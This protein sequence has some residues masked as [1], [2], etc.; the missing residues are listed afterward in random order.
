MKPRLQLS[1]KTDGTRVVAD[2][3][4]RD[5]GNAGLVGANGELNANT[6]QELAHIT[7][8]LGQ[9]VAKN[10]IGLEAT[11]SAV[12]RVETARRNNELLL[13]AFESK[14]EL[15]ALGQHMAGEIQRVVTRDGFMRRLLFQETAEGP[16]VQARMDVKGVVAAK[17]TGPVRSEPV[18]VRETMFWVD[19]FEIIA[20][21]FVAQ[22]DLVRST[23]DLLNETYTNALTSIMVVE[24]R[25]WKE[26]ADSLMGYH[27]ETLNIANAFLPVN[28]AEVTSYLSNSGLSAT[29]CLFSSDFWQDMSSL[30]AWG[31]L[32]SQEAKMEILAT[33]KLG[34]VHGM[35]MVSDHFRHP[36]HKVLEQGEM[37]VVSSPDTH[38]QYTDRFGVM[39]EEQT[40]AHQGISGR[41]WHMSELISVFIANDRSVAK[42]NRAGVRGFGDHRELRT[43]TGRVAGTVTN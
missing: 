40:A 15:S 20:N 23:G 35:E 24:D 14:E 26:M 9:L 37:Y 3:I 22:K 16:A 1:A 41:G 21:P 25:T 33:G 12:S 2:E 5:G 6:R 30:E 4:R 11:S 18:L 27:N 13:A 42:L 8:Q 17:A 19:E 28:L 32:M 38:G 31:T 34:M 39:S 10:N 36:Q 29:T 7:Q 43:N